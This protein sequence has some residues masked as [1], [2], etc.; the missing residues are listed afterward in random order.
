MPE[1]YLKNISQLSNLAA[2]LKI[3]RFFVTR[4]YRVTKK[5]LFIKWQVLNSPDWRY[6]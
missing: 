3:T 4:L 1:Q 5:W 2:N 6:S